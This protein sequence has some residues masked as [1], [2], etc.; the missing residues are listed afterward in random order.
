MRNTRATPRHT[1]AAL[2]KMCGSALFQRTVW[3][4]SAPQFTDDTGC[5]RCTSHSCNCDDTV[6]KH[7]VPYWWSMALNASSPRYSIT[8]AKSLRLSLGCA[9]MSN[10]SYTS[11]RSGH[12]RTN[13]SAPQ[14]NKFMP[15]GVTVRPRTKPRCA[16]IRSQCVSRAHATSACACLQEWTACNASWPDS[17]RE[18]PH[19]T[20]PTRGTIGAWRVSP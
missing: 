1:D 3:C 17:T 10:V 7:S 14:D 13:A 2:A 15:V 19:R 9:S 5:E 11:K 6:A 18:F 8:G 20:R 16:V 12:R 4:V